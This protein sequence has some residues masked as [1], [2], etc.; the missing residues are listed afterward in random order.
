MIDI[1][2]T[3]AGSSYTAADL[4]VAWRNSMQRVP[5]GKYLVGMLDTISEVE[6]GLTEYVRKN[7]TEFGYSFNQFDKSAGLFWGAV[8]K[9]WKKLLTT[10]ARKFETLVLTVHMR[11]EFHGARP[12]GRRVPKG[13]E[14]IMDITS[15]YMTLTRKPKVGSKTI[16]LVPSATYGKS[17]LARVNP[18]TKKL[19]QLLPPSIPDASPDGIR[20]YLQ[21][22][23]DFNNLSLKERAAPEETLSEDDKLALKSGIASDEAA[24]AQAELE[25]IRLEKEIREEA[26]PAGNQALQNKLRDALLSATSSVD[27]AR[28]ILET[29]Y[30]VSK[31]ADLSREQLLDLEQHIET[32]KK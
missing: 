2:A 21:S 23:P 31:I 26:K 28:S 9:E 19:E 4:F 5:P 1:A 25:R 16:P 18:E 27:E 12:T 22:P 14:T 17:R 24:K 10:A 30:K 11:Q 7:P 20:K 32:L 3:R 29:R 13:K 15:L 8:K 6:D